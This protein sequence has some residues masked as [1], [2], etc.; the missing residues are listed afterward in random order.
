MSDDQ[1][2][3]P[4][5][6]GIHIVRRSDFRIRDFQI[7]FDATTDELVGSSMVTELRTDIFDHWLRIAERASDQSEAAR[8]LALEA[9][10]D[11]SAKFGEALQREFEASL[12]AVT[13]SAFAI[14][15]FFASVVEHTPEARVSAKTRDGTIFE[16]FKLAFSLTHTQL[17]ALRQPLRVL[18]RLRR[19]AVHPPATWAEPVLHPA[20]NLGMEPRFVK[21]RA[22]NAVNAQLLARKLV[23]VSVRTPRAR[24]P[25]LVAW[26]E[27]LKQAVPAPPPRPEWEVASD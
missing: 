10:P 25:A 23:A 16:T 26:C 5:P 24:Y 11:A 15:A 3:E 4:R 6:A 21:F 12:I 20:F 2:Q 7:S 13:A 9:A 18:F 17:T 14:D 8:K 22:E 27:A 1:P 19:E